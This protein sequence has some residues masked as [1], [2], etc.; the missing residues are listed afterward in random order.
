M[1]T[2]KKSKSDAIVERNMKEVF[3]NPPSTLGKNQT[4]TER[5]KQQVAIALSKSREA[6]ADVPEKPKKKRGSK[7]AY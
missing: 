6:G 2:K 3:D 1:P 4:P 5:R 7:A